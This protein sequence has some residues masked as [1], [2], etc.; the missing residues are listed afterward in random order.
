MER[1]A[2]T[3][4][5]LFTFLIFLFLI[6]AP[7]LM[8]FLK[9]REKN[10]SGKKKSSRGMSLFEALRREDRVSE[11][12]VEF[13]QPPSDDESRPKTPPKTPPGEKE[14]KADRMHFNEVDAAFEKP[15]SEKFNTL[16]E[17]EEYEKGT[18]AARGEYPPADT[19]RSF[20][21]KLSHLPELK[22][23]VVMSEILGPPKGLRE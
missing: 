17:T 12:E 22:K 16:D 19:Q 20:S 5:T 18:A 1:F 3:L 2:D 8:A 15:L 21:R 6:L 10:G 4:A 23:A 9:G 7:M 13:S 11:P 14:P